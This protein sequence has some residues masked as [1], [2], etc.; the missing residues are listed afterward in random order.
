MKRIIYIAALLIA[1]VSCTN[2]PAD[3]AEKLRNMI[4]NGTSDYVIVVAHRGDW[5]E[6]PENSIASIEHSIATG[7]DVVE[8]DL[9]MTKDSVLVLMHDETVDRTTTGIGRVA[10]FTLDS[11]QRLNLKHKGEVVPESFVPTLEQAM[12]AAKGKVLI[13]LD[14]ADRYFDLVVPVL[15]KTGTAKQIIMKGARSA[16]SVLELYGQYL[17]EIIYMPVVNFNNESADELIKGHMSILKPCAYEL[18]YGSEE[19]ED[20]LVQLKEEIGA[21]SNR[22]RQSLC[23][24]DS[25]RLVWWKY[26]LTYGRGIYAI[27]KVFAQEVRDNLQHHTFVGGIP[28]GVTRSGTPRR[29]ERLYHTALYANA[30]IGWCSLRWCIPQHHPW[31]PLRDHHRR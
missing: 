22:W 6:V 13:N 18:V 12:L 4:L 26:G 27:N 10:D 16:E 30:T 19:L 15:E 21:H 24:R 11:L 8:V 28:R 29:Q 17:D 2:A 20:Y 7:V 14:K 31:L 5:R 25:T 23:S 9:Q 1:V 3:R